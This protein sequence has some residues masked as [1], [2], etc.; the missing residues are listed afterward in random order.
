MKTLYTEDDYRNHCIELDLEYIGFYKHEHKGTMVE[1]ICNK[2]R[3]KGIQSKDWS[4]L[5]KS[6]YGC[7]YCYGRNKT[8]DDIIKEIKND[9]V[10]VLSEYK[11]SEHPL[12]CRCKK[13]GNTWSAIARSLTSNGSG[14]PL[15]GRKIVDD[16]QRKTTQ[17]FIEELNKVNE[18][19]E[20]V[21]EYK[22]THSKIK[23]KCKLDGT[24]WYGYPANLLNG[25][26]GCPTCN[27][28]NGERKMIEIL[29]KLGINYLQQYT[30]D[31]CVLIRKLKFDAFDIDNDIAFE[32]N[33]E[34]HYYPVDFAYKGEEWAK[35]QFEA[36]KKR[37]EAKENYCKENGIPMIIVP[38][39]EKDNM[40]SFLIKE[41]NKVGVKIN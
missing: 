8:T 36:T 20:V 27:I 17:Q 5:R 26:A 23:C 15:C 41:L 18:A 2:H 10:E 24:I 3:E 1:F 22:N 28:S 11:G 38:Y 34:Q 25:S 29:S 9:N 21:G 13:C 12:L 4:H 6:V 39:W 14:C 40:E 7:K 33:G 31:D 37:F 32:Y 19:I 35:E 30:I 16:A